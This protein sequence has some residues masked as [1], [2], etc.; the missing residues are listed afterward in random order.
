MVWSDVVQMA[1]VGV[2]ERGDRA[3]LAREALGE[4]RIGYF[5]GDVAIQPGIMG[6]IHFAHTAF[7]HWA[8]DFVRPEFVAYGE[9]HLIES[10]KFISS[11]GK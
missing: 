1:D 5:D 7:A 3:G 11:K 10:A 6:A 2:I 8:E 4:L 9:R